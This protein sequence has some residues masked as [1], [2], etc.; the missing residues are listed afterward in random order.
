MVRIPA[1]A[2]GTLRG[3]APIPFTAA[4]P[5]QSGDLG[6]VALKLAADYGSSFADL[7]P[8]TY[9]A[10]TPHGPQLA[11]ST[12]SQPS[13][14]EALLPGGL[15]AASQESRIP[16]PAL[17]RGGVTEPPAYFTQQPAHATPG[18]RDP[19]GSP[20]PPAQIPP[21]V[22]PP[23]SAD[24]IHAAAPP[25]QGPAD[26][27][28]ACGLT[29]IA[30]PRRPDLTYFPGL[31]EA[32]EAT[33]IGMPIPPSRFAKS[34]PETP[35]ASVGESSSQTPKTAEP[36]SPPVKVAE[37]SDQPPP[38]VETRSRPAAPTAS[39]TQPTT[40]AEISMEPP[41]AAEVPTQPP[42][43][44]ELPSQAPTATELPERASAPAEAP[45]QTT[46]PAGSQLPP[47]ALAEAPAQTTPPEESPILPP[48]PAE[49]P[50]DA[51]PLAESPNELPAPAE[52]PSEPAALAELP[53][54]PPAS[55]ENPNQTPP[56]DLPGQLPPLTEIPSE[57]AVLTKGTK[58]ENPGTASEDTSGPPPTPP[59]PGPVL[60][61]GDLN[62]AFEET[63]IPPPAQVAS[64]SHGQSGGKGP[65]KDSPP[66][67]QMDPGVFGTNV[68]LPP[69][70]P[71]PSPAPTVASTSECPACVILRK[72]KE[73]DHWASSP[74]NQTVFC[75]SCEKNQARSRTKPK[76]GDE[77]VDL[78]AALK[79]P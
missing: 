77:N 61:T 60:E 56:A 70:T 50:A 9:R 30:P 58:E 53:T 20:F 37:V 44:A 6:P 52:T 73:S 11:K 62:V 68:E 72:Q 27:I 34:Q 71:L 65:E 32:S 75:P 69:P 59:K 41:T 19:A 8:A 7:F 17:N 47:P 64:Q 79:G 42:T 43:L 15:L 29:K 57:P 16:L 25:V 36:P 24:Q 35:N 39:P 3:P 55:T 66:P 51:T 63:K 14:G 10:S 54:Q 76:S 46:P 22:L 45:A 48:A 28:T 13:H 12:A 18:Y 26:L 78:D 1:G 74:V 67:L 21:R 49:A 33:G 2:D 23:A 31:Q 5:Q 38:P 4:A 40:P